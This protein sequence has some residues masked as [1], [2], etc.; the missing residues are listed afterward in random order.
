MATSSEQF[1]PLWSIKRKVL[2]IS[3][4]IIVMSTQGGDGGVIVQGSLTLEGIK[5]RSRLE[6]FVLKWAGGTGP[7]CS[8]ERH[9]TDVALSLSPGD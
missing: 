5:L 8:R 7:G 4:D 3:T 1:T 9:R 2:N 6:S